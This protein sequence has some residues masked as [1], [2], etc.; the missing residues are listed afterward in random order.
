[1]LTEDLAF[2]SNTLQ[3]SFAG[4]YRREENIPGVFAEN[5][6]QFQQKITWITGI[7]ADRHNAFGWFVTPRSLVRYAATENTDLRAS[8]GSG[9]RT[10][11]LFSE[12]IGLLTGSRDIVFQEEL[13]PEH[14]LSMGVNAVQ[15][16]NVPNARFTFSADL[17]H[18]RFQN[19][20]FPDFDTNPLEV[21]IENFEGKSVSN[22][23]Q[24]EAAC[25]LFENWELKAAYNFLEVYREIDGGKD[26]LPFNPAHRLLGVVSYAATS[27]KWQADMNVHWY[28][29]QRLPDT[30]HY[31][32]PYRQA[33]QSNPYSVVSVQYTRTIGPVELY[34]GCEN[35][36][37]FRQRRPIVGWED[38]FGQYFDTS[39]VW[40]PTRG[41]ELYLGVRYKMASKP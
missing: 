10:V 15:R 28:G 33:G 17:Y 13:K 11:N 18:I 25:K 34:A 30:Q 32:E 29:R 35:I 1:V 27:K 26:I 23:F 6:L 20:I 9:W 39:F 4:T 14:A 2:S 38:P 22:G 12:N 3:R 24:A 37:D 7:R 5:T 8:I 19:Q 40:G 21:V 31:P 16:W 36:L 41:R